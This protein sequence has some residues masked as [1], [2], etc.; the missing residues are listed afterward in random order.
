MKSSIVTVAPS[1]YL[2]VTLTEAKTQL[3]ILAS[4]TTYDTEI[5]RLIKYATQW[6]ERRY[7]ISIITQTRK[8]LQDRFY[9]TF[10]LYGATDFTDQQ[11]LTRFPLTIMY[12][13][14]QSITSIQYYDTTGTLQ[15]LTANT[16]YKV[17][18]LMT[19]TLGAQDIITPRIWPTNFWPSFQWIPD[20]IQITYVSGF[21]SDNTYVP[22]P[23]R[24]AILKVVTDG[25]ENRLEEVEGR[26]TRLEF[27]VDKIMSSYEKFGHV[28]IYA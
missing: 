1:T 25:F 26:S 8:Q 24:Q 17:Q 5:T 7:S 23:I 27:S 21:G 16:D 11:L 15:T 13:P 6:V 3:R 19:P 2:A 10:P 4:D 18:G 22:D 14:V 9:D 12:A 20:A 28:R